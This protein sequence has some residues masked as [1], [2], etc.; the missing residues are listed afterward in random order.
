MLEELAHEFEIVLFTLATEGYA[1]KIR[2]IIDP[3]DKII[4]H[5]LSREHNIVDSNGKLTK[6]LS[7]LYGNRKPENM[8]IIDNKEE[9]V[10]Q[11]GNVVPIPDFTGQKEDQALVLLKDYLMEFKKVKDVRCKIKDDFWNH[12]SSPQRA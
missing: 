3:K 4:S 1:N 10:L 6:D 2:K 12:D 7:I 9:G 5:L 11:T 8:I